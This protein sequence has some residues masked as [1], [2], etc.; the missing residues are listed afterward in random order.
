MTLCK[1]K[2]DALMS[3]C[4][5]LDQGPAPW[6]GPLGPGQSYSFP[7]AAVTSYCKLV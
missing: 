7:V 3:L 2:L 1:L 5:S 6:W 4:C